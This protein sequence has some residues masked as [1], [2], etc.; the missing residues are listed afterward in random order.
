ML[1]D[2]TEQEIDNVVRTVEG[3][4]ELIA[5]GYENGDYIKTT[6]GTYADME[7]K[8]FVVSDKTLDD[9][10]IKDIAGNY[11]DTTG[12]GYYV[13]IVYGT[14]VQ[15][16][17]NM[18]TPYSED[19]L[20]DINYTQS[21]NT[22]T[23]VHHN[24]APQELVLDIDDNWTMSQM[25]FDP[26]IDYPLTLSAS[27]GPGGTTYIYRY[28]V[29]ALDSVTG[30]ESLVA[31]IAANTI[32]TAITQDI[33]AV[34]TVVSSTG[35][36]VGQEILITDNPASADDVGMTEV[37][38][39]RYVI[40]AIAGNNITLNVDS[41]L[42]TA[43]VASSAVIHAT[44]VKF[45]SN[46]PTFASPIIVEWDVV[47][48]A[49]EYNVYRESSNTGVYGLIGIVGGPS[50]SDINL[51]PDLTIT[52][53]KQ[54][55][56]FNLT[57]EYPSVVAYVQQRLVFANTLE[58]N[59]KIFMS[60][61][62]RFKNFTT[63]SPS[64]DDDAV[65]FKLAGLKMNAVRAILDLGK[66]VVLTSGGEWTI[67]GD[68]ANTVTPTTINAKQ[69]SYNGCSKVQPELV[70]DVAIFLQARGT[71]LRDLRFNYEV[72]GYRGSDLTLFSNHFFDGYDIK[73]LAYQ[74][75]PQSILWVVRSDG[76]LLGLTFLKDQQIIAWHEHTF[77]D[78]IVESIT[79]IPNGNEDYLSLIVNR[80]G[81]RNV[82]ILTSRFVTEASQGT[83]MD[84]AVII[85]TDDDNTGME[86]ELN[87]VSGGWT[88][89]DDLEILSVGSVG[90]FN[91]DALLFTD[92]DGLVT[93]V[94]VTN[95]AVYP[96]LGRA[97]KDLPVYLQNVPTTD[98][99][100]AKKEM[101]G[102]THLEGKA[103]SI[104]ADNFL[105]ANPNN[106]EYT[107]YIVT[108]GII[109]LPTAAQNV[110]IGL[111][112]IS[113]I[114]TLNIDTAQGETLADK[115]KLIS[116]VTLFLEKTRGVWVGG[117]EPVDI[118]DSLTE[119]KVKQFEDYADSV[120]LTTS[121]ETINIK[122]EWN[123]NGRVFI[124][125]IDPL[126]MTVLSISSG[127]LIPFKG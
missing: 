122:P 68:G 85:D 46:A 8:I 39:G 64:Q 25:T 111:P 42:F 32:I 123:S 14:H 16:L 4:I 97:E 113:D 79:V 60:R 71:I 70:D 103:V 72:D 102:L 112:Y 89:L 94:T 1:E 12:W 95:V 115:D 40:T 114:E 6:S 47:E 117:R 21:G 11:V 33:N 116:R 109:T 66:M 55:R 49:G 76:V 118:I 24:H 69:T 51:D 73:Y 99:V 63:S 74:Q 110:T 20:S 92:D 31:I 44:S 38:N 125:Q 61:I 35:Y 107:E 41:T 62:G 50:Y 100:L 86:I 90:I 9:F 34:M 98:Y 78:G 58:D 120:S 59:E 104:I 13:P 15:K 87:S 53:P 67:H 2:G 124:R 29:T 83:F 56:Y 105:I 18:V 57:G 91:G 19:E 43:Y 30:E 93:R 27:G 28:K 75:I 65:V 54:N 121:V 52:P 7:N 36:E 48:N 101:S 10:K 106:V 80:N 37:Y 17:L 3:I 45:T 22:V 5:H 82:E 84:S 108:D 127:G 119:L 77:Q 88:Y 23:L 81:Q 126:P 96:A 26:E